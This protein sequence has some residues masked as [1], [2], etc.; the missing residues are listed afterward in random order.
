MSNT[1]HLK[2]HIAGLVLA[3]K[4]QRIVGD[5]PAKIAKLVALMTGNKPGD[6]HAPETACPAIYSVR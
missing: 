5:S 4:A 1:P 2:D 6:A 3:W